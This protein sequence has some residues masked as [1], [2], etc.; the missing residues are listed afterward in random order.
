[1][2]YYFNRD[3]LVSSSKL[4]KNMDGVTLITEEEYITELKR[5][6]EAA[7][8]EIAEI[9]TEEDYLAALDKLGVSANE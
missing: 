2:Y 5:I 6:E 9:A 7:A 3:S 8:A 4:P 1:M